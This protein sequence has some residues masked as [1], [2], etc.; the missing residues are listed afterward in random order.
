VLI[1]L[2]PV[3]LDHEFWELTG[4]KGTMPDYPGHGGRP[5]PAMDEYTLEHVADEM[6][7]TET[8]GMLDLVGVSMG[9]HVAQYIAI[10][11]PRRVRS[12]M[13]CCSG[14][15]GT[16][17]SS[18]VVQR[19][20]RAEDTLR[21]G[22]AGMM[23]STLQ[24]WFTDDALAATDHPGVAYA[25]RRLLADDPVNVAATW[26][27][28]RRSAIAD[29]LPTIS[30]PVTVLGGRYD[31]ASPPERVL[32]LFDRIP[33]ARLEIINGPHMLP[34]ERPRDFADSVRR[35]LD[36]VAATLGTAVKA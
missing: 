27:M 16:K 8:D 2:H 34:L 17:A 7:G 28:L 29:L 24:R 32:K 6:A 3:G 21:L 22:M 9:A 26:S 35:H 25:R 4:L 15:G 19:V 33:T 14:L 5:L 30:A 11:H 31:R 36:W 20:E 1:F 10:R 12:L 23:D 13:L 18:A